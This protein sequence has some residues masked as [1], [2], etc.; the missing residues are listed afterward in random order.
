MKNSI[1]NI[2]AIRLQFDNQGCGLA[3]LVQ[4]RHC[5]HLA[6]DFDN[7]YVFRHY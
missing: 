3:M 4:A 2:K 5:A 7:G 6:L 1:Q